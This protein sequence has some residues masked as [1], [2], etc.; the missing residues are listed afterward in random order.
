MNY[1]NSVSGQSVFFGMFGMWS[2][3][4]I[5]SA[6][7]VISAKKTIDA[8]SQS[9]C[10]GI[11]TEPGSGQYRFQGHTSDFAG[12]VVGLM[13]TSS[14]AKPVHYNITTTSLASGNLFPNSGLSVNILSGAV[15]SVLSG[16]SV[17]LFSG[18][19]VLILSGATVALFSGQNVGVFSGQLSGQQVTAAS[20]F[21]KDGYS[22][23]AAGVDQI[24]I[25]SGVNFRQ[26]QA[27][28]AAAVGGQLSGAGRTSISIDGLSVPGTNR[29]LATVDSSGNRTSV[30]ISL[31]T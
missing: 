27:I 31:P 30:S 13:F 15:A 7:L 20:V 22:L 18:Q 2:G 3:N 28:I 26:S 23:S 24:Q 9:T 11:I 17:S 8:G 29:I 6:G 19:Q 25:E 1:V 14:G 4:A 12:N 10:S 5:T 16:T 21:D